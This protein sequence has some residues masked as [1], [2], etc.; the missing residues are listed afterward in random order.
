MTLSLDEQR[1]AEIVQK[2]VADLQSPGVG[3]LPRDRRR[4]RRRS[5]SAGAAF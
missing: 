1:I 2:V 3:R 4:H 5:G